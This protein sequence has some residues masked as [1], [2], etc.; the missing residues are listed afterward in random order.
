MD[1]H[2]VGYMRFL[3]S[4]CILLSLF[5]I[6]YKS[7][8]HVE[9]L[10]NLVNVYLTLVKPIRL[11]GGADLVGIEPAVFTELGTQLSLLLLVWFDTLL[12]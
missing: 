3:A 12:N 2:A 4:L 6:S 10:N 7:R 11:D 8:K 9:I 5:F 1:S